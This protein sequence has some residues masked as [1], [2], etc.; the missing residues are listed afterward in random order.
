MTA[1]KVLPP[2]IVPIF[3]PHQGCPHRCIFCNQQPITG[4][5]EKNPV[6]YSTNVISA[7]IDK[8]LTRSPRQGRQIQVAFYGG[9]FTGLTITRQ[10]ELLN[11]VQP[12]LQEGRV[13]AIRLSTRPDYINSETAEF[14]W[15]YGVRIVEL[16]AQSLSDQVLTASQRGHTVDQT[17][18]ALGYLTSSR[19]KVGA[20]LMLGLPQETSLS[21]LKGAKRLALMK[22][23]FIRIYPVLVIRDSALETLYLQKHYAPLTMNHTIALA[24]RIKTIFKANGIPVIRIGLPASE[25]LAES[26]LA[27]PYHPALG[28]FIAA[29]IFFKQA[30][31]VL[32]SRA[33]GQLCKLT[34]AKQ[35]QSIFY[36]QKKCNWRRLGE[37]GL[38]EDVEMSF[39]DTIER[40][41]MELVELN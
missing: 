38:L 15:S 6:S 3:I 9:S 35:D 25:E 41:T 31:M 10:Q 40:G 13:D 8:W 27:G 30:K 22:P 29:R 26:L 5:G 2:L 1:V 24:A 37:L 32:A 14:L 39:E 34:I 7:E 12:F 28:E 11:A 20:Q 16:G 17:I 36:G 33:K 19:L 21:T 23:D 4:A 18:Q